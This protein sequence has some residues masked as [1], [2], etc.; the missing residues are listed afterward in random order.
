[1]H[2]QDENA[3]ERAYRELKQMIVR[4]DLEPGS[5]LREATVSQ[6]LDIGRTPVRE[7]LGRLVH[8]GLV[9]VRSRQGYR[10]TPTSLADVREVFELRLILEPAAVE[11]AIRNSSPDDLAQLHGLA[12]ATHGRAAQADEYLSDHLAF[13][14]ALAERSGNP[15]IAKAVRDLLIEMER[16]LR[17]SLSV[18]ADEPIVDEHHALYDALASGDAEGAQV[19]MVAQIERSRER[20]IRALVER[21]N[22]RSGLSAADVEVVRP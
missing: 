13:H 6:L 11:M 22:T 2:R 4:C 16:L 3:S 1:M 5:E 20:V 17:L 12:H 8:D 9:Q 19:A 21:V 7:A 18:R 14:V 15:R 10:V